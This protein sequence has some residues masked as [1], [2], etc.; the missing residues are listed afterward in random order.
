MPFALHRLTRTAALA[1]ALAA[2]LV[3]G[4]ALAQVR[5]ALVEQQEASDAKIP[6]SGSVGLESGISGGTLVANEEQ[7]RASLD[8]TLSLRVAWAIRPGLS[9][10]VSDGVNK[11][12]ITNVDSGAVRPYDTN[13]GD[14]GFSLSW[15]PQTFEDGKSKPWMLP[16]GIISSVGLSSSLPTSRASQFQTKITNLGTSLSLS[17]QGLFDGLMTLSYSFSFNKNFHR[18]ASATREID[19]TVNPLFRIGGAEDLG[20]GEIATTAQNSSFSLRNGLTAA[21]SIGDRWY[22]AVAYSLSHSWKYYDAPIDEFSSDY[23]KAGRG[24]SDNQ[25]GSIGVSYALTESGQTAISA[26]VYTG[27][28]VF[29]A[30]NKTLRFPFFDFRS[31]PDNYSSFSLGLSHD[32]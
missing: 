25:W 16:G 15:M 23:A 12:L 5:D 2:S 1:A 6:I 27:S 21:F 13:F 28:P 4:T 22:A 17:R 18:Y 24:R 31:L 8:M 19:P 20:G 30:D 14:V 3:S 9:L 26:Q 29:T 32:F 7:R 11:N 10:A